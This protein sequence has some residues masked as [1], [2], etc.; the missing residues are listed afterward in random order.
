MITPGTYYDTDVGDIYISPSE[1][2]IIMSSS[3]SH[4]FVRVVDQLGENCL[5]VASRIVDVSSSDSIGKVF[6]EFRHELEAGVRLTCAQFKR[7]MDTPDTDAIEIREV[8]GSILGMM[9]LVSQVHGVEPSVVTFVVSRPGSHPTLS[10]DATLTGDVEGGIEPRD[11]LSTL[12]A[13]TPVSLRC[14]FITREEAAACCSQEYRAIAATLLAEYLFQKGCGFRDDEEA[15]AFPLFKAIE[16]AFF[17]VTP[18]LMQWMS[19]QSFQYSKDVQEPLSDVCH[20]LGTPRPETQ[21]FSASR[22]SVGACIYFIL[23][24]QETI[25]CAE[26]R[27]TEKCI[28]SAVLLIFASSDRNGHIR[29]RRLR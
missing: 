18:E 22:S 29:D 6:D 27:V 24:K 8:Q 9:K 12:V 1:S 23:G 2:G 21:G 19:C 4:K 7:S 15:F 26:A 5:T 17:E 16:E 3:R 25:R 28:V 10:E 20:L 14:R 13:A 11:N